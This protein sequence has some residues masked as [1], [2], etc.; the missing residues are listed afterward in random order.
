MGGEWRRGRFK[1]PYL[2]NTLWDLGY[3]VDTLETALTWADLPSAVKA[4][5]ETLR[6]GLADE[7]ERVL[8]FGHVSHAY[9]T[10]ASIYVTYLFR[11]ASG[12]EETFLR[13]RKLKTAASRTIVAHGGTISHQHGVGLDHQP[14]MEDEKGR[15]GLRSLAALARAYDPDGIMNPGKLIENS[16]PK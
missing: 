2:R 7:G 16:G 6:E 9:A 11:I 10:G 3:A 12:A 4:V 8:A 13:W 5:L 1:T 15:L 14:W